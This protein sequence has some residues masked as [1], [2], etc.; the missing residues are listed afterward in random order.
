[1]NLGYEVLILPALWGLLGAYTIVNIARAFRRQTVHVNEDT[2]LPV[3]KWKVNSRTLRQATIKLVVAGLLLASIVVVPPGHRGVIYS[4]TEG[5][6]LTERP[7]GVSFILP[8]VQ[9]ANMMNV[10]EQKYENL[11]VFSQTYDGLEVTAQVGV[12]Y[13]VLPAQAAELF[14]DVGYSYEAD[15]IEPAVLGLV[16]REIGLVEAE[17]LFYNRGV[18]EQNILFSLQKRL[19]P[20]GIGVTFV[21]L[22]DTIFDQRIVD[23]FL[24]KEDARQAITENQRLAEAAVYEAERQVTLAQG[25][26]DAR[27]IEA[28]A[29]AEERQ[30]LNMTSSEYVWFTR[31]DGI[32]PSTF[33]IGDGKESLIVNLP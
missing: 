4:A 33:I 22:Q 26:A 31:W 29:K 12:N 9:N 16:K 17:K 8:V 25:A 21:A 15:I 30:L 28:D 27:L 32:L 13:R 10:R 14:R 7:E 11:E 24:S 20:L 6:Q 1:M 5:V 3:R 19:T 18:V 23:R 2:G